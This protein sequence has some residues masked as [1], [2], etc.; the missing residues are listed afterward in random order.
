[1]ENWTISIGS[2]ECNEAIINMIDSEQ[3]NCNIGRYKT[4]NAKKYHWIYVDGEPLLEGTLS[5][6]EK[7]S[8][9][10]V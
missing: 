5:V 7:D 1:M 8:F 3:D 9:S 10:L 4:H 2:R 6:D